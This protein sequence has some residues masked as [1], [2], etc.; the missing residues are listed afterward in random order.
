MIFQIDN[1]S[2]KVFAE[3]DP[4]RLP[5]GKIGADVVLECTGFF[6]EKHQQENT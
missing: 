3:R 1:Q 6:L 4:A 5:W 2:I